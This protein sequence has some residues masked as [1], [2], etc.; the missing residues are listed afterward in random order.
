MPRIFAGWLILAL[1]VAGCGFSASQEAAAESMAR[2][3]AAVERRDYAAALAVC[4]DSFFEDTS[5]EA[6]EAELADHARRL[7]DL[8]S[9]EA[10]SWNVKKNVGAKAGT[11][12]KVVY[13]TRYSRQLAVERFILKKAD[14]DFVII[15]HQIEARNLP[16]GE[17]HFI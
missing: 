3:F 6:R 10:L 8:L 7:G 11:F 4:A 9:Y 1:V 16:R 14:G 12:V 2:Y 13:K 5:R 17:T 15:A